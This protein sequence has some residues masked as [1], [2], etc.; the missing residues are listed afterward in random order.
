M[1]TASLHGSNKSIRKTILKMYPSSFVA[2]LTTNI[3]LMVDTLLA[4]ALL[5]QQ[6]IAAVAIGLPSIGIFQ[7]LVQ[8]IIV[9]TAIKMAIFAGRSDQKKLNGF[10]SLGLITTAIFAFV[11][12][13][14]C[15]L[16]AHPLTQLFGGAANPEAGASATLYLKASSVCVFMGSLNL[17]FARVLA[18]Y[19]YQEKV[20]F[21]ALIA[22]LGN[23]VF[24]TLY[25]HLLPPD[26][27][28][29]GLGAG[30][31]TGGTIACLFSFI[32]IKRHK[33][34]LRFC[35][36]DIDIKNLPEIIRR[37]LPTS[38]NSLADNMVAGIINNLIVVG[39]GGDTTALAVYTAVKGFDTFCIS[40][41]KCLQTA[42]SPLLGILYG[43]RDKN[44]II[45][46]LKE[47]M[48]LGLLAS[49]LWSIFMLILLPVMAGFYGMSGNPHFRT[50]VFFL[51]ATLPIWLVVHLLT[52][53]FEST[54]KPGIGILFS[55]VPDSIIYPI[56]LAVLL[57]VLK[58][59]AIWISY[60]L[61]AVPFLIGLYLIRSIR[62]K[63]PRL[64]MDRILFLD[65]SIRDNVPMM[66][67]S[68]QAN[69]SNVTGISSQIHDFLLNEHASQRTAYMT[70][71]CLE[72]LAADF[73]EH[74]MR[75]LPGTAERT[76]MDIKM[77]ADADALQII[78]R[79][80]APRYNPLDFALDD[81][82]FSKVGVK[83]VQKVSRSITYSYVYR[84]NIVTII[85]D[86]T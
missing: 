45:T 84:M 20:F 55:S 75:D 83:L 72:E 67:I 35:W 36:K 27:A 86:K 13:S 7:A 18:L 23:L 5:G 43:S 53:V 30:T 12:M 64:N 47:S 11:F 40:A 14:T 79:N 8:T 26:L 10:Y 4:G 54:E 33:I 42:I 80:A 82:S 78:I 25:I 16:L 68:I 9:G 57:P 15:F 6:S 29:M 41:Q 65:K 48:K 52:Q 70:S 69:N 74:T 38:G 21:S 34:P 73:V 2:M 58:Y 50:G 71:L 32:S 62:H 85:V 51:L 49:L 17:F 39:F 22:I 60:T 44:G 37:G 81:E 3:A 63:N 61:C 76:I 59:N 24:S 66:D 46:T 28:I 77:F 1:I 19:G 56:M 31:W